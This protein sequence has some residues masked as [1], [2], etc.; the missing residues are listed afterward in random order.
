MTKQESLNPF[1]I[2][3]IVETQRERSQVLLNAVLIPSSSGQLSK[4]QERMQTICSVMGL[5]PFFIRSIVETREARAIAR[6]KIS[7]NPFFIR[8]IVET[9]KTWTIL[10]RDRS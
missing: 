10:T 3:S 8:S 6:E 2:R 1:F 4:P 7:L 5:N 9:R